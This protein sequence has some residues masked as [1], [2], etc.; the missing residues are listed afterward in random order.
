MGLV[1]K[2]RWGNNNN[3]PAS[4]IEI[5][6]LSTLESIKIRQGWMIAAQIATVVAIA[7]QTKQTTDALRLVNDT[8]LS[9]E[10]TIQNGFDSLETSIERLESNLIENLSEIK[11]YLFNVDKKLDQL[12][13]LVK[14]SGA[15]KSAENNKQGFILYKIGSFKEAIGQLE[16]SLA[17]NPLNIEAYI[18]LGF[19]YLRLENLTDSIKNFELASKIIK[20][21]FSYYE[22][23]SS[24]QLKKT[25]V[26]ILDN[27]SNLYSMQDH[28]HQSIELMNKILSKD[29]D[30]K[31]EILTK[32]KLAKYK[33]IIKEYDDALEIINE[34]INNQYFEPVALAVANPEFKEISSRI[35]E[36]LQVKLEEIKKSFSGEEKT[37][38]D[39]INLLDI[40]NEFKSGLLNSIEKSFI[41]IKES[42]NYSILLTSEFKESYNEF[43]QYLDLLGELKLKSEKELE[44]SIQDV[45]K[46]E[47]IA[48]LN[49]MIDTNYD[50]SFDVSQMSH[51]ILLSKIKINV[52]S[53]IN[54]KVS[55]F[56]SAQNV[57]QNA[58]A[59]LNKG[60]NIIT[61]LSNNEI[62]EY[63][64]TK[65]NLSALSMNLLPKMTLKE[66]ETTFAD[67]II[68]EYSTII[69]KYNVKEKIESNSSNSNSDIG[70]DDDGVNEYDDDD[71]MIEILDIGTNKLAVVKK[72]KEILGVDLKTAKDLADAGFL[73]G[74]S[75][76]KMKELRKSLLEL[77]VDLM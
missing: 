34:L 40:D 72:I 57:Y 43:L 67:K 6:S 28:N 42:S 41:A 45:Q 73:G 36:I 60:L 53:G 55:S 62:I 32:Y 56:N 3:I 61:S 48:E 11:W 15:T 64:N 10:D 26:F 27:L 59:L 71:N 30:K 21:D 7:D 14:F 39:K 1:E 9:I 63:I 70:D 19:V 8:L 29:I 12:I 24:E 16:K 2:Y 77:G 33:C 75:I 37:K 47:S 46:L 31:T 17:E 25:E 51:R 22:E 74:Y 35:L 38:S 76:S 50:D 23:I 65:F 20:E 69:S 52:K 68:N 66:K 5:D 44:S 49:N 4:N 54:K 18:N 13:N 58:E